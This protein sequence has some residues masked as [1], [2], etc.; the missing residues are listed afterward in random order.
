MTAHFF[1]RT[2]RVQLSLFLA[3]WGCAGCTT[4]ATQRYED[5]LASWAASHD[6]DAE[7][8]PSR[9]GEEAWPNM[10]VLEEA[11]LVR[12]VLRRN[13]SLGAARA[14]WRA[15]LAE[16]P[17]AQSLDHPMVS[18]SVAPLSL[19]A[20]F[21]AGDMTFGQRVMVSQRL[22]V[23]DVLTA[24]ALA[25]AARADVAAA[26]LDRVRLDLA[27]FAC[28]MLLEWRSTEDAL[29]RNAELSSV[30]GAMQA[31]AEA[32]AESGTSS[33]AETLVWVAESAR[34]EEQ[35][36][37]LLARRRTLQ[38]R[39]NALLHRPPAALLPSPVQVNSKVDAAWLTYDVVGIEHDAEIQAP[40]LTIARAQVEAAQA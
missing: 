36:F 26:Q 19:T 15:A 31:A 24:R 10:A 25:A 9:A 3:L 37:A 13:P 6:P 2:R 22:P 32:Q 35:R 29:L 33:A 21:G 28:E 23:S 40:E 20:A 16:V 17:I 11:Q 8:I 5:S 1:G 27:L 14:A 38:V 4:P 30:L 12:E 18:V 39:L 34:N 7:W